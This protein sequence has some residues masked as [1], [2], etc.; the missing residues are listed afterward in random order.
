[1]GTAV[2]HGEDLA[3]SRNP[4]PA[5]IPKL[6]EGHI[7]A[8][9]YGQRQSGDYYDFVRVN[10]DRVLLGIFDVAGDLPKT[11][12]VMLPL[13]EAFR[14]AGSRLFETTHVNELES[15]QELWIMLNK[16][17]MKA[18]DGVHSCPAFVGCYNEDCQ[19]FSYV[20]AGHTPGLWRAGEETLLLK[21]TA[22][23]LG[24]FS[25]S[26]PESSVVALGR[27]HAV[28][29]VSKGAVEAKRR[30]QEFGIERAQE[31]L[32]ETGFQSA[33]D[34]CVGFLTCVRRFMGTPPTHNDVTALCL[35]RSVPI[36]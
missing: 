28:L 21:A 19:T 23:P 13:Q 30:G 8:V 18:A 32:T 11:R 12:S 29:L 26:I 33:H 4:V 34:A 36:A 24:L 6:R 27:G 20:N 22:L 10:R 7:A 31:F 1:M 35:I 17:V 2:K 5:S 25:H 9:Y 15:M 3:Q 14:V 16:A